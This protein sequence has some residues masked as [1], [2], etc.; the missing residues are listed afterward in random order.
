VLVECPWAVMRLTQAGVP[1]AVALLGTS[2]SPI[3][4]AWL[5]RANP[6][7]LML[8]GDDAGRKGA[9][10]IRRRLAAST[11]VKTVELPDGFEP[12]DLSDDALG[13]AARHALLS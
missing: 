12:E 5:A 9:Q 13:A 2:I 3:Q 7:V 10:E 6:V 8:D 4:L 11:N 1:A